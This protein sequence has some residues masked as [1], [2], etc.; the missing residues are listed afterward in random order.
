MHGARSQKG[1]DQQKKF[2]PGTNPPG[3]VY[4]HNSDIIALL[5]WQQAG[6]YSVSWKHTY[7]QI[8]EVEIDRWF[9]S[10]N[11]IVVHLSDGDSVTFSVLEKEW[12][13]WGCDPDR[14]IAIAQKI[15]D[16][17]SLD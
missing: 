7:D 5:K 14:N 15:R 1:A 4:V 3:I 2:W 9:G 12:I 8:E 17:S 13:G 10:A 16:R 11:C 6:T